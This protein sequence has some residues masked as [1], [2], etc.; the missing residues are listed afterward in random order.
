MSKTR[1]TEL[2]Q[3]LE[4]RRYELQSDLDAKRR[5]VRENSG[6]YGEMLGV[7][8]AA[9]T[10]D[11]DLQQDIDIAL[12]EMKAEALV[13]VQDALARL[14]SGAY[15]QC[16]D[17][18]AEISQQRLTALPFALRCRTCE[19]ERETGTRQPRRLAEGRAGASLFFDAA[20]RD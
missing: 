8:D 15:G 20:P 4:T 1:G 2:K 7:L 17:C 12:L 19:E 10:S 5:D 9:E 13:H 6:Y 11:V 16:A 3:M 18:G 14:A